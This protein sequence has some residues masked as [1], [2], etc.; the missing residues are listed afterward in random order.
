MR[1]NLFF[2]TMSFIEI[3]VENPFEVV[4]VAVEPAVVVAGLVA[5]V[6]IQDVS[7]E[8]RKCF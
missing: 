3:A 1:F 5:A 4:V 6:E 7:I 8:R 2:S